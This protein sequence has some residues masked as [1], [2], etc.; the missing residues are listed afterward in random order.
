M[1]RIILIILSVLT[2]NASSSIL[3][4]KKTRQMKYAVQAARTAIKNTKDLEKNENTIRGYLRDSLFVNNKDLRLVLFDL[5]KRQYEVTNEKMYRSESIDTAAHSRVGKRLFLAAE[6]LDSIDARPNSK[7]VSSPSYRKRN[8][9]YLTQYRPNMLKGAIYFMSRKQWQ[10][11]WDQLDIYLNVP[12]SPL[13]SGV[14]QDTTHTDF[15]SFLA[16]MTAYKLNDKNKAE[17]YISQAINYVPR[18][19]FMLRKIAEL[20]VAQ[21]DTA[22]YVDILTKGFRY[23]PQSEHFFPRLI[24]YYIGKGELETALSF[25]DEAMQKDSLNPLFLYAK[26][27]ILMYE[28][29]YGEALLYGKKVLLQNDSLA[30]PNY[31]I[32]YIYY[33]RAEAAMANRDKSMRQRMKEAQK[34]Y[35]K[36]LPYM[37]RYRALEPDDVERWRPILYD[38]YLNLNMGDKFREIDS[39]GN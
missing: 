16:V 39:L 13:F 37:E 28:K 33:L 2:I 34:Q 9:Q 14:A 5:L 7:G 20:E 29:N 15:A 38:I 31:N 18:R 6:S 10:D 21:G 12:R 19:E 17:K 22:K 36:S 8:S 27:N 30:A 11:A 4:N 35:K 24:D 26:H 1:R 32:G 3:D 25:T 23:F